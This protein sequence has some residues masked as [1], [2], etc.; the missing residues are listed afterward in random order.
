MEEY[1][2][3]VRYALT[4]LIVLVWR[5]RNELDKLVIKR[6]R[7]ISQLDE[8]SRVHEFLSSNPDLDDEGIG[9]MVYWQSRHSFTP[10]IN[11][12]ENSILDTKEQIRNKEYSINLLSTSILQIARQ[13]IVR[14]FEN[15]DSCSNGRTLRSITL[16]EIIWYGRN[17][18]TH[19]EEN[20]LHQ[21]TINFFQ[22]LNTQFPGTFDEFESKNMSFK[23]LEVL[24]WKTY[25][26]LKNDLMQFESAN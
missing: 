8:N 14:V 5:E 2:Y 13:G 16:K 6:D 10:E 17:Q 24:N 9:T 25:E 19:V 3:D 7:L 26:N 15:I 20:N 18:G 11:E 23:I 4:S 1:L 22:S 21:Q 12:I